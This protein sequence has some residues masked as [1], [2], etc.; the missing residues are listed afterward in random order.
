MPRKT[1]GLDINEDSITAVQVISGLKG[2][3]ITACAHVMIK[4]NGDLDDGLRRIFEGVAL[5]S[6]TCITSIPAG[7]VS[8]RNLQM[9]FKDPRKIRKTLPYEI[10]SMLPFPIEE[11]IVDFAIIDRSD[12]T[13]IL[14][15][16]IKKAVVS[17]YLTKLEAIGL[18]P[19]I[20]DIRCLPLVS[21]LLRCEGVPDHG[22]ILDICQKRSTMV[23]YLRRR[24][25][26]IRTF[27]R[28][29][30]LV[31]IPP[32]DPATTKE[33]G[34][35]LES[36]CKMVRDTIYAFGRQNHQVFY[37][38]K[39]FFT[40]TGALRPD[41]GPLLSQFL[42]LPSEQ[43]NLVEDK[44][45]RM[46]GDVA[47]AWNAPLMDNAL[48]L[49]LRES[50]RTQGFNFR[51]DEFEVKGKYLGIKKE[52]RKGVISIMVVLAFLAADM[53]IGYYLMKKKYRNLDQEIRKVFMQTFPD[54]KRIVDPLAQMKI[55]INQIKGPAATYPGIDG[56]R[57]VLDLL[58]DISKRIPRSLDVRITRMII[59]PDMVR[60][61]GR[62]T[63]F[64]AVDNIKNGLESSA[65]FD[66]VTISSA[67]LD[68]KGK[69]VQFEIKL[70]RSWRGPGS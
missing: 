51:R 7:D 34:P 11:L 19:E 57:N 26:L 62:T 70:K 15:V 47:Q 14:A 2:Y 63:T 12:Q 64:N 36:L 20:L 55:R 68:R 17:E 52:L 33:I 56:G 67:N 37:P 27:A 5:K 61:S 60:M 40:G 31:A 59:D 43:I 13:D 30:G 29:G 4:E 10:D 6:D 1:L 35:Y 3:Q 25:A 46:N 16:S 58:K 21:W 65:L 41:T 53:G 44:R 54:V 8:Y 24:I 28:N 45:I 69:K 38:E 23:L 50:K 39:V 66:Q 32:A 18:N 49:A 22:I 9:P 48:S 42:D